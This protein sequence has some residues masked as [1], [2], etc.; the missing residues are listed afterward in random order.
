MSKKAK[1]I[2]G[3]AASLITA[4]GASG[5]YA[6][7]VDDKTLHFHLERNGEES[8]V[9]YF[10]DGE[11]IDESLEYIS[12][13]FHD[14]AKDPADPKEIN[15]ELLDLLHDIKQ[16]LQYRH[17]E[18]DIR[19]GLISGYRSK[20]YNDILKNIPNNPFA[21]SMARSSQHSE[22]N[23]I[24]FYVKGIEDEE[25]RD[26]AWCMQKGGVGYYP[27]NAERSGFEYIH[28]DIGRTRFWGGTVDDFWGIECEPIVAELE[29]ARKTNP[30]QVSLLNYPIMVR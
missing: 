29:Q 17:P 1:Y 24:D 2:F 16:V 13:I 30:V 20:E 26:I 4:V 5:A 15:P 21:K 12:E 6:N 18:K 9:T 3:S 10:S 19:F 14:S 25:L 23:A 28:V 11:Y 7:P 8:S 22:A 27:E